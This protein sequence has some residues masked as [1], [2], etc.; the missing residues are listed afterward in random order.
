MNVEISNR[1]NVV[2]IY[3]TAVIFSWAA[4]SLSRLAMAVWPFPTAKSNA[5][6]ITQI[7]NSNIMV[8]WTI[9]QGKIVETAGCHTVQSVY[10][11]ISLE[12][13]GMKLKHMK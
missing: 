8:G 11:V 7:D 12:F 4:A 2:S 3:T 5:V 10:V 13:Y 1:R 6:Y 9:S